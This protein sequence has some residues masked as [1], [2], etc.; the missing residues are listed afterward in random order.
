MKATQYTVL[1]MTL[2]E[3]L[4]PLKLNE[5]GAPEHLTLRLV[6]GGALGGHVTQVGVTR[7]TAVELRWP[8]PQQPLAP[9]LALVMQPA[10]KPRRIQ[11]RVSDK[12]W[13]ALTAYVQ[14][15]VCYAAEHH[16]LV[17]TVT[18]GQNGLFTWQLTEN[19]NKVARVI[20]SGCSKRR[21][22]AKGLATKAARPIV[23]S[24]TFTTATA[25]AT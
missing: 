17:A 3:L 9:A 20:R 6:E 8:T 18:D 14:S 5:L 4:E 23:R 15:K 2:G 22:N 21:N 13:A 19:I 25:R 12:A 10:S 7:L 1:A 16:S 24:Y 11:N